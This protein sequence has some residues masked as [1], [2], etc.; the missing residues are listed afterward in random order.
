[1]APRGPL[2]R[3]TGDFAVAAA[4]AAFGQTLRGD[5]LM[6]DFSYADVAALAKGQSDFWRQEFLRLVGVAG[7][8]KEG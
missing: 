8:L 7:S 3:P 4:V 5:E 2:A 6:K 1:M